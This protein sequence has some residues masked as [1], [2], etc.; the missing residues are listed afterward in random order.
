M[1]L[2]SLATGCLAGENSSCK[3]NNRL[4]TGVSSLLSLSK[5][6]PT[7]QL[8]KRKSDKVSIGSLSLVIGLV[9]A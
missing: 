7:I 5:N 3:A 9:V 8:V 2:S 4:L 6:M 1:R